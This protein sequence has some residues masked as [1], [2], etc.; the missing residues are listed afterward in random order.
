MRNNAFSVENLQYDTYDG[1]NYRAE[2][3]GLNHWKHDPDVANLL[4]RAQQAKDCE[5]REPVTNADA[6]F[7]VNWFRKNHVVLFVL[8][9]YPVCSL[10][11]EHNPPCKY[12]SE[13]RRQIIG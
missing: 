11:T 10:H 2:E 9:C 6:V 13:A 5:R 4:Q 1:E 3:Y 12:P 7:G 8:S